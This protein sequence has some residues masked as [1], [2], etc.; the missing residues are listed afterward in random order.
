MPH[1]ESPQDERGVPCRGGNENR[2][3]GRAG[4][5]EELERVREGED[6]ENDAAGGI[7]QLS[8]REKRGIALNALFGEEKCG[9]L[10]PC[11]SR[12][13]PVSSPFTP[14]TSSSDAD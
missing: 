3:D 11:E 6:G 2:G 5:S 12:S 10:H 8:E 7:R 4:V 9:G 13:R 1:A 14:T